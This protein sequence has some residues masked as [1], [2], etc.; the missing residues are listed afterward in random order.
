MRLYRCNLVKGRA[1][2]TDQTLVD[3]NND[4]AGYEQLAI[5]KQVEAAMNET[6]QTVLNVCEDIVGS[7]IT[8]GSEERLERRAKHEGDVITE[9]SNGCLFTERPRCAL[10][11][12]PRATILSLEFRSLLPVA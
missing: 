5:Q 12:D 8:D 2:T 7:F 11:R 9:Q 4:F 3:R 10:K 1:R 6:R